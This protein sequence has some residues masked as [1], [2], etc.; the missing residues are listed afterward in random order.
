MLSFLH[1]MKLS[2][3]D[4]AQLMGMEI[5]LEFLM[6]DQPLL[7]YSFG[8]AQRFIP[9]LVGLIGACMFASFH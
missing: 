7:A 1:T 3:V 2:M 6:I 5:K 8:R 9:P 4:L